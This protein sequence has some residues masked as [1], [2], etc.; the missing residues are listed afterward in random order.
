MNKKNDL[1]IP[2]EV[3]HPKWM[4]DCAA[5]HDCGRTVHDFVA[6]TDLWMKAYGSMGGI[7]CYDCFCERLAKK[8]Q[9]AVF[10]LELQK[11]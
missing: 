8:K 1:V 3:A 5:C 9:Y 4:Y 7:L 2:R 6:P 10:K 11:F